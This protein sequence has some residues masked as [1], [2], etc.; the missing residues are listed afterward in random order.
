MNAQ[1]LL[2]A[3]GTISIYFSSISLSYGNSFNVGGVQE[4]FP[5][6]T[7]CTSFLSD[8]KTAVLVTPFPEESEQV[9]AWM[10][11]DGKD[12]KLKQVSLKI[13]EAGNTSVAQYQSPD[14]SVT[15]NYTMFPEIK[16]GGITSQETAEQ[17]V[18]NYKGQTKT[19]TTTG[20][21]TW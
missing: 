1:K 3:I 17:I 13:A 11:I 2:L 4:Q 21:C 5:I 8:T 18:I 20:K 10:N 19:I 12:T 14:V 6:D 9:F 15:V 7:I 16:G